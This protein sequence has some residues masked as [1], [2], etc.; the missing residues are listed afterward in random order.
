MSTD[1]KIFD[2]EKFW[3]HTTWIDDYHFTNDLWTNVKEA[4]KNRNLKYYGFKIRKELCQDEKVA[5]FY[6]WVDG[7]GLPFYRRGA[8]IEFL[9]TRVIRRITNST[10]VL[11]VDGIEAT[12]INVWDPIPYGGARNKEV[13]VPDQISQRNDSIVE[14]V[15]PQYHYPIPTLWDF[16]IHICNELIWVDSNVEAENL[17]NIFREYMY[18]EPTHTTEGIYQLILERPEL[19]HRVNYLYLEKIKEAFNIPASTYLLNV[20]MP[21]ECSIE[22]FFKLICY[23]L[24]YN[25]EIVI[26]LFNYLS[27]HSHYFLTVSDLK[28]LLDNDVGVKLNIPCL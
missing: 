11:T 15:G 17:M 2:L 6:S 14:T 1:R 21:L 10:T 3:E 28:Y 8:D 24:E 12:R 27:C 9:R 19:E 18:L 20:N 25:E 5:F 4:D 23:E 16:L 26:D 7:N 22:D 13:A